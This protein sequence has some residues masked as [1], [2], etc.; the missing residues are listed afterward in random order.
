VTCESGQQC[1]GGACVEVSACTEGCYRTY[2][3]AEE[4]EE[5]CFGAYWVDEE[6]GRYECP[7][8]DY[9]TGTFTWEDFKDKLGSGSYWLT[10]AVEV[11]LNDDGAPSGRLGSDNNSCYAFFLD[12]DYITVNNHYRNN[13]NYA[14]CE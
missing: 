8:E 1:I 12:L 5:R 9:C 7:E 3:D 2:W 4:S 11:Y 10:E 13:Y 14:L 6:D